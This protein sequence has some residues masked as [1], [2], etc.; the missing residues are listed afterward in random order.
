MSHHRLAVAAF[1]SVLVAL[2]S[3]A[4]AEAIT[5]QVPEAI[6][7]DVAGAT[8]RRAFNRFEQAEAEG[9]P[10]SWT[11]VA[12]DQGALFDVG[13]DHRLLLLKTNRSS[14]TIL[15]L[16][17]S[18]SETVT[19]TPGPSEPVGE[20]TLTLI[21]AGFSE[22]RLAVRAAELSP[23]FRDEPPARLTRVRIEAVGPQSLT[24]TSDTTQHLLFAGQFL[25]QWRGGLV[26]EEA[27]RDA[28]TNHPPQ[29]PSLLAARPAADRYTDRANI[30]DPEDD[31]MGDVLVTLTS[32]LVASS[33]MNQIMTSLE[34]RSDGY[35]NPNPPVSA[36]GGDDGLDVTYGRPGDRFQATL[37]A[38][39]REGKIKSR[40]E[41]AVRIPMNGYGTFN[42]S[43]GSGYATG[44][45]QARYRGKRIALD[46]DFDSGDGANQ[47]G[48]SSRIM[49]RDGQT[50]LVSRFQSSREESFQSGPP[51]V[52]GIPWLGPFFGNS[53]NSSDKYDWALFATVDVD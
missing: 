30:L 37:H 3:M 20:L 42:Y 14:A 22:A 7:Q 38:L 4:F 28:W 10:Q 24:V 41:A 32:A 12:L 46:F 19:L 6:S 48:Q 35:D 13:G 53:R 9:L 31:S 15:C 49:L 39:E 23:A 43:S 33:A 17:G 50:A 1:S 5:E 34:Y 52:T 2:A 11:I 44:E 8:L 21:D 36:R 40:S 45:V 25:K 29:R 51:L 47:G 18:R 27:L 16:T 26:P